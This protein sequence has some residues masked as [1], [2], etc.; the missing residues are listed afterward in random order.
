MSGKY[1]SPFDDL[2]ASNQKQMDDVLG[3]SSR[4]YSTRSA[5]ATPMATPTATPTV[6]AT[7]G[8]ATSQG[9]SDSTGDG[10]IS[11]TANGIPF[12]LKI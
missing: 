3:G 8:P 6:T 7:P 11:G 10:T 9:T 1:S 4:S 5:A 2:L 12:S